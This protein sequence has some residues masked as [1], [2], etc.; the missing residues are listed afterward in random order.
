VFVVSVAG[1]KSS[2][3][4]RHGGRNTESVTG[5]HNKPRLVC[6]TKSVEAATYLVNQRHKLVVYLGNGQLN[7]DNNRAGRAI[8]PFVIGRKNWMFSQASR[9]AIASAH[10]YSII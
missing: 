7:I 2:P 9:G 1:P 8:K 5:S 6:K 3:K 4:N 10:L